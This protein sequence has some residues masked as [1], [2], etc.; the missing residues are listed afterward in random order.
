MATVMPSAMSLATVD[1]DGAPHCRMVLLKTVDERGFVFGTHRDSPKGRDLLANPNAA[2]VFYWARIER[3]VRVEGKARWLSAEENASI[4]TARPRGAQLA[5]LL[6]HQSEE[7][8]DRKILED[9]YA[10]VVAEFEGKEI[11]PPE[12]WGGF[13][14]Q[15]ES[16]EFWQGGLHRLHDRFV[17]RR[18]GD[19]WAV[20]RLM[21]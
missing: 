20:E 10:Q 11:P 4:F 21:P 12:G 5:A 16:I 19:G 6:G 13:A 15:P 18:S 3:Q 7:V 8:A 1:A 17:F 2:L 14:I 9:R